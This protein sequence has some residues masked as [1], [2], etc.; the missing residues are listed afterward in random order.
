MA[1]IVRRGRRE[2]TLNATLPAHRLAFAARLRDL[3]TEC[4][5]PPYRTLSRLAHCGSGS[6]CEAAG[7]NRFPTWETTRGFV[8]G[9]LRHAGREQEIDLLLPRW[10]HAWAEA[11]LLEQAQRFEDGPIVLPPARSG[12]GAAVPTGRGPRGWARNEPAR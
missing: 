10:R 3:R 11:D 4:G 9:C 8:T 12:R 5:R 7:G 6:L 2:E 1:D